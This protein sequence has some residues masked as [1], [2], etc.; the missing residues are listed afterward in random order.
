MTSKPVESAPRMLRAGARRPWRAGCLASLA[1]T[2][3]SC[4]EPIHAATAQE[5]AV[6]APIQA[7]FDAFA[8]H[9]KA[10]ASQQLLPDGGASI[11]RDGKI[12]QFRLGTL[13]D[14]IPPDTI[15]VEERI[16]HPL[17]RI[18]HEIAMVWAPYETL[19]NDKVDHCG[20]DLFNLIQVEGRWMIAGVADNSRHDCQKN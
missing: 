3:L 11:I 15:K 16:R 13:V 1:V 4:V 2:A 6:L 10:A 8:R 17:I 12:L 7:L 9:D 18:D 20:T 14:R 5:K 19:V